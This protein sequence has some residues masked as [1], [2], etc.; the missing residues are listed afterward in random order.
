MPTSASVDPVFLR[1]LAKL[2]GSDERNLATEL[3]QS[4]VDQMPHILTQ[5]RAHARDGEWK[6]LSRQAH[7][8]RGLALLLGA[9][10][11]AELARLLEQDA[12]EGVTRGAATAIDLIDDAWTSTRPVLL[13]VSAEVADER[14]TPPRRPDAE[15]S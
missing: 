6:S 13:A 1:R 4:F 9:T 14:P 3:V 5:L 7:S 2:P 12:H 8:L 10:P 15:R 11:L